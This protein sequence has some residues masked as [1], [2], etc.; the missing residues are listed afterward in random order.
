MHVYLP[1]PAAKQ[2]RLF[3]HQFTWLIEQQT[4][5]VSHCDSKGLVNKLV[6]WV[7]PSSEGQR[8]AMSGNSLQLM[9][10]EEANIN[11]Q[12]LTILLGSGDSPAP[13]HQV[14]ASW[15]VMIPCAKRNSG[16][17][18]SEKVDAKREMIRKRD[19]SWKLKR[20]MLA[21]TYP[22]EHL[23]LLLDSL[24]SGNH[25]LVTEDSPIAVQWISINCQ[26]RTGSSELWLRSRDGTKEV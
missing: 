26:C 11:Y 4:A 18:V 10:Y 3:P 7:S 2:S 9:V 21:S 15:V 6:F 16:A 22:L 25:Q 23:F 20:F 14:L 24:S 19:S 12:S 5:A 1:S 13:Y 17:R 8:F